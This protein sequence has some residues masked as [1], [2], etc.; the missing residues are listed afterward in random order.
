MHGETI[1][2]VCLVFKV[3]LNYI[4][5]TG[6]DGTFCFVNYLFLVSCLKFHATCTLFRDYTVPCFIMLFI[7]YFTFFFSPNLRLVALFIKLCSTG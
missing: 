6:C 3:E 2:I 5:P 7:K 1:K 4:F